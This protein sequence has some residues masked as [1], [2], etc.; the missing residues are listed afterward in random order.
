MIFKI[1]LYL[2]LY[3]KYCVT[4]QNT[5]NYLH[6]WD[7]LVAQMVKN[8]PAMQETWV[9]SLGW[10]DPLEE[11]LATHS[12]ILAWRIPMD[13]GSWRA[14]VHGVAKGQTRLSNYHTHTHTPAYSY[15]DFVGLFQTHILVNASLLEKSSTRHMLSVLSCV[16]SCREENP[17]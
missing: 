2:I 13:R 16:L 11:G 10:E 15:P 6:I 1:G 8:L 14:T 12:S 17:H 4:Y 9:Q 3:F 7:S 5:A